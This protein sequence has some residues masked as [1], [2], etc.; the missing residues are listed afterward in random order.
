MSGRRVTFI[1]P[2]DIE[3]WCLASTFEI[4]SNNQFRRVLKDF[5]RRTFPNRNIETL[6]FIECF[7]RCM[8]IKTLIDDDVYLSGM[9]LESIDDLD[10][11]QRW[12]GKIESV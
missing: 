1:K 2:D 3:N 10:P 6:A 9:Y 12:R 5:L 8:A 11:Y 4:L 7:E